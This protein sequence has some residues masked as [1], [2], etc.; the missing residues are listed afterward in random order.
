MRKSEIVFGTI[1]LGFGLLLLIGAI[2]DINIWGLICPVTLIGF[3]VWLIYRTRKD[4]ADGDVNIRF[5]GDIRRRDTWKAQNE[6]TWGFVLDTVLDF[7]E[8]E[9]ADGI[10][11][12][13]MGAFVNDVKA[14]IPANLGVAIYSMAFM[15]ESRINGEKQET[16]FIPFHWESDNFETSTKKV[17]LKPTCFVSEIKVEQQD[18]GD[19]SEIN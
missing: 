1:I 11:T 14:I 15:T 17:V 9:L 18:F 4:P 12:F 19:S 3:G 10:T 16:F 8:A 2:F 6:E 13:R 5:V 7:T